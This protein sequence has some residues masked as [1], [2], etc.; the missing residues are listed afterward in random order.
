MSDQSMIE[1]YRDEM[2]KGN[3]APEDPFEEA[4]KA[5]AEPTEEEKEAARLAW[6]NRIMEHCCGTDRLRQKALA[7]HARRIH[8]VRRQ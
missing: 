2:A 5:A 6:N 8:R 3:I 7:Q 1:Y 4:T